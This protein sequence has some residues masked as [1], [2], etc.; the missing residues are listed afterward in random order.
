MDHPAQDEGMVLEEAEQ[1]EEGPAE[2]AEEPAEAEASEPAPDLDELLRDQDEETDEEGAEQEGRHWYVIHSY[3]GY[4]NKVKK[5]L[6]S[7]IESMGMQD[8]IFEVV[9]P[10]EEVVELR[11]GRRRTVEQRIFPGYVLV[12]MILNDESW[13]VVRNTPGVTGFVG[14]GTQPTPLRDEEASAILK[15]MEEEAP[16]VKVSFRI[17]DSVRIV[18]G[19]FTDFMGTVDDLNLEKG[20]VRLLVSFFGRETP[21]EL[22]FLQVE[23]M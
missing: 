7:R 20:K 14:S 22:D 8:Y 12:D 18:D 2:V 10:T 9:V 3:S 1:V 6:E 19:P 5:N 11:D 17:G 16:K 21:V 13:F 23:R 15:R 4:E